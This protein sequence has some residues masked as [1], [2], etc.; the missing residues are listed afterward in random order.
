MCDVEQHHIKLKI[1]LVQPNLRNKELVL[2][3]EGKVIKIHEEG[4]SPHWTN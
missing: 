3:G 1:N 2:E 4:C